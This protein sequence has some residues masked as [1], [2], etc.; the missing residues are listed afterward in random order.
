[1]GKRPAGINFHGEQHMKLVVDGF[2][3][4]AVEQCMWTLRSGQAGC[5]HVVALE[6][7]IENS[8]GGA[9]T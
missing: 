2:L 8:M 7:A 3:V 4:R 6:C 9:A 5:R 1:M